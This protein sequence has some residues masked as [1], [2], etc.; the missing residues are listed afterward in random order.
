MF[1]AERK[2]TGPDPVWRLGLPVT[3][4]EA[5]LKWEQNHVER[6]HLFKSASYWPFNVQENRIDDIHPHSMHEWV[7]VPSHIDG[8]FCDSYGEA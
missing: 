4:I 8:A 3:N 5:A 1:D 6:V 7:G 2:I